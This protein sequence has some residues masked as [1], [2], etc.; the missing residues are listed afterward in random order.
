M[1]A[2]ASCT[3]LKKPLHYKKH[4]YHIKAEN[5]NTWIHYYLLIWKYDLVSCSYLHTPDYRRTCIYVNIFSVKHAVQRK[6]KSS[7][8]NSYMSYR[9]GT[10]YIY[11]VLNFEIVSTWQGRRLWGATY[12]LFHK[13]GWIASPM[14]LK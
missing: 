11:I 10:Y 6:F 8:H 2:L 14:S 1:Y 13:K 7:I 5:N 3:W 9:R 4:T 12:I